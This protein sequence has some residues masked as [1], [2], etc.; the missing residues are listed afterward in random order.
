MNSKTNFTEARGHLEK[1]NDIYNNLILLILDELPS[2]EIM[3]PFSRLPKLLNSVEFAKE[4]ERLS[5]GVRDFNELCLTLM[6]ARKSHEENW[7]V[8]FSILI[9]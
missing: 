4:Y 7:K 9:H 5:I 6:H 1:L 3:P 2:N 8:K